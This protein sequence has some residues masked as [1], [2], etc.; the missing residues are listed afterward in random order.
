MSGIEELFERMP[1][2]PLCSNCYW[3][4]KDGND[5][6]LGFVNGSALANSWAIVNLLQTLT[7]EITITELKEMTFL[8]VCSS[9]KHM[10]VDV[11]EM[12]HNV[13]EYIRI[14]WDTREFRG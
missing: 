12:Y 6:V 14:H 9:D 8:I 4:L 10:F 1:E 7:D 11:D 3:K 13:F 2:C 5:K